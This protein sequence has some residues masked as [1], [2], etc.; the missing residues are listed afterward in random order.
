MG[1]KI[2]RNIVCG[3]FIGCLDKLGTMIAYTV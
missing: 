3:T 2:L 1:R